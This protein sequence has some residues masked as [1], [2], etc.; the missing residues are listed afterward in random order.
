MEFVPTGAG[1][2]GE[3]TVDGTELSFR[4]FEFHLAWRWM[5]NRTDLLREQRV[6]SR[7]HDGTLA[8]PDISL[9]HELC[10]AL[11]QA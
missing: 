10:R 8:A 1:N 5:A 6:P 3:S 11:E 4:A 9:P 2:L 7:P